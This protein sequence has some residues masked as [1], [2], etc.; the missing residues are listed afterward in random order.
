MYFILFYFEFL[1]LAI[2]IAKGQDT[3]LLKSGNRQ[4]LDFQAPSYLFQ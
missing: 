2:A 3:S 4:I 1:L